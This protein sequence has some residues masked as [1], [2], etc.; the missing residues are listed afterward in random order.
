MTDPEAKIY[1]TDLLF[2][3]G[4]PWK[5][6]AFDLP[7]PAPEDHWV[8]AYRKSDHVSPEEMPKQ[9]WTMDYY[10]SLPEIM[11]IN[12]N[13]IV[14]NQRVSDLLRKFKL[15]STQFFEVEIWDLGPGYQ[16]EYPGPW[17]IVNIA[18]K[19]SLFCPEQTD[20]IKQPGR[21][22]WVWMG[23]DTLDIAVRGA[24][25]GDVD[26]WVDPN[27]SNVI[28]MTGMMALE[29]KLAMIRRFKVYPCRTVRS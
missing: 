25:P 24:P 2:P 21:G 17:Y 16:S 28:F 29:I 12:S 15:G 8:W 14:I 10:A 7:E 18:E 13:V 1:C 3:G 4:A 9:I 27:L 5:R 6:I 23:A 22:A 20:R 19:R 11:T 26:L